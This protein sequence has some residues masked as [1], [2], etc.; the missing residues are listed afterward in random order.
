VLG[1]HHAGLDHRRFRIW[2]VA[3][4][5]G[6]G[7]QSGYENTKARQRET[8]HRSMARLRK[9]KIRSDIP[10]PD[11][12]GNP[13]GLA[14]RVERIRAIGNGQ[15]PGVAALAW[16]ILTNNTNPKGK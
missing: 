16:R 15:V 11:A 13:V 14:G 9:D 12:F 4:A 7:L 5:A 10:A 2:I 8:A 3:H 6:N 1:A